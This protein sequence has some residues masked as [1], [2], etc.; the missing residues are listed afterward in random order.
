MK[1]IAITTGDSD[2][3]GPEVT[4]KALLKVGPRPG[5]QFFVY[6]DGKTEEKKFRTLDRRFH[7]VRFKSL[8]EALSAKNLPN[9]SL[10]EIVDGLDAPDW[11]EAAA[12]GCTQGFLDGIVTGPLSKTLIRQSGR[13]EIGHTEILRKIAGVKAV[14]QGYLGN[15]FN[16][17]LVTAHLP[18]KEVSKSLNRASIEDAIKQADRLRRLM[19]APLR[20]K[21]I[22]FLGLNP[23]AG[24]DGILGT[25]EKLLKSAIQTAQ[26]SG[27]KIIGPLVPDAAFIP[28]QWKKYSVYLCCY[29]DQGLIPFKMTH[30][31]SSG[32]Q[33]SLGL[34]FIRT[35]VDHGTAKEIAGKDIADA[36]SMIDAIK[37]ALRLSQRKV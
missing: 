17:V 10:I 18:L 7:R 36:G 20:K 21:P 6:R 34:P 29:H 8:K 27:T 5:F 28:G 3:I 13:K 23:H 32:A 24:E 22:A 37:W 12:R 2:G 35:S 4:A 30:G 14:Y 16:V 25:E 9:K 11:V 33:L 1:R 19:P 31:R 26:K 15:K